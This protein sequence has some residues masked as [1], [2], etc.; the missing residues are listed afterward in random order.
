M[1]IVSL[2]AVVWAQARQ[3]N[4]DKLLAHWRLLLAVSSEEHFLDTLLP[5]SVLFPGADL[6]VGQAHPAIFELI[7]IHYSIEFFEN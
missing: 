7:I 1:C 6:G 4:P 3:Q 5:T 2:S